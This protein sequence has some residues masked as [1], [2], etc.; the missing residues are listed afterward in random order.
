[1]Y[2]ENP[3]YYYLEET[4]KGFLGKFAKRGKVRN[5]MAKVLKSTRKGLD[6]PV[7]AATIASPEP[8]STLIGGSLIGLPNRTRARIYRNVVDTPFKSTGRGIKKMGSKIKGIF[9]KK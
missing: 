7:L 6:R 8:I 9:T 1:M 4:A 3:L 2:Q 5:G